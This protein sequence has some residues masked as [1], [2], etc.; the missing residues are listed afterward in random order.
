MTSPATLA[1]EHRAIE[2]ATLADV[3]DVIEQQS[4]HDWHRDV[5]LGNG[6]RA[7]E[8]GVFLSQDAH[9]C[10]ILDMW[11]DKGEH[12]LAVVAFVGGSPRLHVCDFEG[13]DTAEYLYPFTRRG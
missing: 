10:I 8:L 11:G 2:A 6:G 4:P 5:V 1:A 7:D 9:P 13:L 12:N 3:Y